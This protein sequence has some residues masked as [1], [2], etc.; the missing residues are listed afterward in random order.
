MA[1][2]PKVIR[3]P[4]DTAPERQWF[5]GAE[6]FELTEVAP[7]P[8][9]AT[10]AP[11]PVRAWTSDAPRV[12]AV[13]PAP[14]LPPGAPP[15]GELPPGS[16]TT[17]LPVLYRPSLWRWVSRGAAAF[18]VLFV[19]AVAWLALTAPL[20][21]SLEPPAPPSITLYA[22]DGQTPIARRG[23]VIGQP[24]DAEKLP[25][26]V[27]NAFVAIEDRRFYS[28][29]G[30]DPRGLMRALVHNMTSSDGQQGGSTITQQLAKNAF[31]SSSRTFGRKAQEAMIALWL[32]AWLTKNEILSRYLSNVYFGDN[33]YGLSAAARHYFNC[34]PEQL[35]VSQASLLAG[36][37]QAPSRLAPTGNLRGA[38]E[39]QRLVLA[40]MVDT[41]MLSKDEAVRVRPAVLNVPREKPLPS[42]GYFADWVL[43]QARD[44][45]GAVAS[46]QRVTTTLE[47]RMQAAAERAVRNIGLKRAQIA[48]VAMRPDGRVVAMVGGTSYA[49]SPFNRATQARR[50]PGSTFK[51]FV[52]L[53]ALRGG[54]V[55]DDIVD[56]SPVSFGGW[57]PENSHGDYQGKITLQ[58]AFAKSSN[59]V[60][61][62][63]TQRFGVKA[64]T[65]AARDLGI[66]TPIG[67]NA[68][69]ALG[70]STVSL[71]ELTSAYA[72]V[73]RGAYPVRP[74]GLADLAEASSP[75]AAAFGRSTDYRRGELEDLRTLLGSVVQS[76]TGRG[77]GLSIPSFGKTGTTQ[78]NRDAW[79]VGYAGE[80][81]GA[82]VAGVWIGNDDNS[83]NA[84]LSGGGIP[85]RV[86]R[87][88]MA[89][90]LNVP[91]TAPPPEP[92]DNGSV[93][94]ESGDDDSPLEALGIKIDQGTIETVIDTLTPTPTPEPTPGRAPRR[95]DAAPPPARN[96]GNDPERE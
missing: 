42:G 19:L 62:R 18:V 57:S 23:A 80:G 93:G 73:A 87:D 17:N 53:A 82:L 76:G 72:S 78:D 31:L 55:P 41:H 1:W 91:V 65:Q 33:V 96:G 89:R 37:V 67:D 86:W 74:T 3:K 49:A 4:V 60:A 8:K 79:F 20:S 51:L 44:M 22:S 6:P 16:Y 24:V 90:A 70:T 12:A 25:A 40:A 83:P 84:A 58:Q 52:Y 69:I 54:M 13:P 36:L 27:R 81:E 34:A 92:V 45:A 30:V 68:S 63:L 71:L 9:P 32:E 15:G 38:R 46:E 75:I 61:A 50:Q 21:K 29:W 77:A 95:E 11:R 28:H 88:F 5:E 94:N 59:V 64:V 2:L 66:S 43:P 56:D 48:I 39:R 47:T 10:A 14:P 7:A 35:S 26:H 85:A